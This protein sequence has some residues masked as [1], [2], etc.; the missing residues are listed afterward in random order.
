[1]L[2]VAAAA[3]RDVDRA[4]QA[5]NFA[6]TAVA[7]SPFDERS[8]RELM[9]AYVAAGDR[10]AALRAYDT[11][12]RTLAD[13]LGISPERATT[14]LRLA[15]L[16]TEP[17]TLPRVR[18]TGPLIGRER[19]LAT[20][21][22]AVRAG[23]VVSIAGPGG[24]GKS[25]LAAEFVTDAHNGFDGFGT[26]IELN[27]MSDASQIVTALTTVLNVPAGGG[28]DMIDAIV[29][30]LA[31]R[32]PTLLV[33][34]GIDRVADE[35][36]D[37]VVAVMRR[38]PDT[39]WIVTGRVPLGLDGET[40]VRPAPLDPDG[41]GCECFL[42]YAPLDAGLGND[43]STQSVTR[44]AIADVCRAV[45]GIPLGIELA[46]HHATE[47]SLADLAQR[48]SSTLLD[49][50]GRAAPLV[51]AVV[52]STTSLLDPAE[53]AVFQRLSVIDGPADLALIQATVADDLVPAA[54][55]VRILAQ[56][57]QRALV[58]LDRAAVQ[59]RYD[60][61]PLLRSVG[62]QS[63]TPEDLRLVHSR[64]AS[65][66]FTRLPSTAAASPR[67]ADVIVL[68]PAIRS[69][70][71]AALAAEGDLGTAL[72]LAF[73]LHRFW[74]AA[75][76]DEGRN[77]LERLL[78]ADADTPGDDPNRGHAEF[79][80]G[81]LLYWSARP[82]A[83]VGHLETATR[84]LDA[85]D[86]DLARAHYFVASASE[87]RRPAT[88]RTH[89]AAAI[90]AAT[91]AGQHDLAA[92][93]G[94]GLAVVE[95]DAGYRSTGM[96]RYEA[97]LAALQPR[98]DDEATVLLLPTYAWMLVSLGRL[99]EAHRVLQRV[100]D[101]FGDEVRITTMVAEAVRARLERH[102]N[103]L[104]PARRHARRATSM[105]EQVGVAR[106]DGLVTPTLALVAL[107]E[108]DADAAT[109]ELARG[110]KAAIAN[111]EWSMLADIIDAATVVAA[112]LGQVDAAV[113]LHVTVEALRGRAQVRR[114]SLEQAELDALGGPVGAA[115]MAS[116]D[117]DAD[118]D[119]DASPDADVDADSNIDAELD[120]SRVADL[121]GGLMSTIS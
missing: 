34:D 8:C 39:G 116:P 107:A 7:L 105:I 82:G 73:W 59:W 106:L 52:E 24:I 103:R 28:G 29:D 85:T 22:N 79:A 58:R 84:L 1:M 49:D 66:L 11:C 41:S 18:P 72:R 2:Q 33:L 119:V 104:E 108:G 32:G 44:S 50:D 110:A 70:L 92:S 111:E 76:L 53:L 20:L 96:A 115:T 90:D 55:V 109:A 121:V 46:A 26:L 57:A 89:F 75:A 3:S 51:Q 91:A 35:A 67:S 30:A 12:R 117:A 42:A 10:A 14:D 86:P 43:M 54:R 93:C 48:L 81:Y 100:T 63:L 23:A 19:E 5:V 40:V 113:E 4:G 87:N 77:W 83:A 74:A 37:V 114:G 15:I 21:R 88:A 102:R 60:Q 101:A 80:L 36:A 16:G 38:C 120:L 62:R 64:L 94:V 47:I 17:D 97:L 27:A 61:H 78:D 13:D 9:A 112:T 69:V 99:D 56:L 31:S 71:A 6:A 68:L 118:A 65:A 45:G 95:F 25:R 98:G